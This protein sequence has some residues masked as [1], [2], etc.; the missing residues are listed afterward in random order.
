MAQL[1]EEYNEKSAIQAIQMGVEMDRKKR[2]TQSYHYYM[3]GIDLLHN[4]LKC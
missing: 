1:L 4:I 3:Q 2:Y